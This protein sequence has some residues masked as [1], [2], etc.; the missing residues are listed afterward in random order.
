[1]SKAKTL[2]LLFVVFCQATALLAQNSSG[3]ILGTVH[4]AQDAFRS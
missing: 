4:D 1:M 3:S 2:Y